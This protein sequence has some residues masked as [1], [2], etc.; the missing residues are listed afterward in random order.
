MILTLPKCQSMAGWLNVSLLGV[1]V[2]FVAAVFGYAFFGPFV[3]V[4]IVVVLGFTL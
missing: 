4:A 1:V 2:V 3:V